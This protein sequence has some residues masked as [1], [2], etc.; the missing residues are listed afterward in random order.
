MTR[1]SITF[2]CLISFVHPDVHGGSTSSAGMLTYNKTTVNFGT[3]VLGSSKVDTV[4]ASNNSPDTIR[5]TSTGV[6]NDVFSVSPASGRLLP[7]QQLILVVTADPDSA[8]SESGYLIVHNEGSHPVDSIRLIIDSTTMSRAP[9]RIVVS[10][11]TAMRNAIAAAVPGDSIL[12]ANGTYSGNG[13]AITRRGTSAFPIVIKAQNRGQAILSGNF[14]FNPRSSAYLTIE[15]FVFTSTN[16]TAIKLES[17]HHVRITRNV[18]RLTETSS[19][20]WVLIGGTYNLAEPFSHNNRIDH[21]LFENKRQLGNCIT[22]DG[23]PQ[24]NALSSQYDR[25]DHNHFRNVGPR[26]TNEME[27]IRVGWSAMSLSSGYTTIEYNLFE[28][29]D[30]DPEIISVKS[31]DN[32]IRY[33][34]FRRSQGTLSLRS[35]NRSVVEGN[36]FFGEGKPG[37]GGVRLYGDDHKIINNYFEGLS[38][39]TWDAP[40]ALTNGDYDG[41]SDLTKHWRIN[42]AVVAFNTLVNNDYGVQIGFNNNGS[43]TRPP[44]DVTIANNVV[45]GSLNEMVKVFTTPVNLTWS[46][47]IM[48]PVPPAVLGVSVSQGEIRVADPLLVRTDSLWKL[49]LS[50]PAIDAATGSYPLAAFDMDGQ[51]RVGPKDVGA[52]EYSMAIKKNRP[53][54]PADVGPDATELVLPVHIASFT[55]AFNHGSGVRLQWTTHGEL[56]NAGF[57]VQKR[58]GPQ[59]A[60]SEIANSFVPGYG[61]TSLPVHYAF[62][63]SL[64]S[65]GEWYYR[66]RQVAMN[67]S[68]SYSDPVIVN[69]VTNVRESRVATFELLQ[70]YPN[71]FNPLTTIGFSVATPGRATLTLYNILGQRVTTLHDKETEAGQYY[72]VNLDGSGLASGVYLYMLESVDGKQLKK[73][74]LMR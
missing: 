52:D 61:T 55:A 71:P 51:G 70:N 58:L 69:V 45:T 57:Y 4:I 68:S 7:A 1:L 49:N 47:N 19:L 40:I 6:T 37:A 29:C 5:V 21:N 43:Y 53:L 38:G 24:P 20:K 64:A 17:C 28:D 30:G 22:I 11:L 3:I 12:V 59:G 25:I 44:R 32:T 39:T 14:Y 8:K 10:T 56:N 16:V 35:G 60:W 62:V 54:T 50:S 66:L 72:R 48:Y 9:V 73:M 46:G 27:T 41:G 2:V 33:N 18:F 65:S 42:R 23:S 67:G 13:I 26:A 15:G 74:I 31:C 36:F 34:T 63:D